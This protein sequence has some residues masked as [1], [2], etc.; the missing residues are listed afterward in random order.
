MPRLHR[1]KSHL[2]KETP[3]A[4]AALLRQ[5]ATETLQLYL[6]DTTSLVFER[7]GA[8]D[9]NPVADALFRLRHLQPGEIDT[10]IWCHGV[11]VRKIK[12]DLDQMGILGEGADL[13]QSVVNF[14][15]ISGW[16]YSKG[17]GPWMSRADL[18]A[19]LQ[20]TA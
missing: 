16:W 2:T 1:A 5:Q 20:A 18:H 6:Q 7:M 8:T 13:I 12:R 15:D 17:H 19:S 14:L 11:L 10:A 9:I 3:E 4:Y